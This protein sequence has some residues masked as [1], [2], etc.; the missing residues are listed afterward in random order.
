M[1]G[2][3]TQPPE[4]SQ[5][6]VGLLCR[7][8]P[9]GVH[10]QKV[11]H[12]DRGSANLKP[13]T[14]AVWDGQARKSQQRPRAFPLEQS[15]DTLIPLVKVAGMVVRITPT[16][17]AVLMVRFIMDLKFAGI[18]LQTLDKG[19]HT[20]RKL[21]GR[22]VVT[23]SHAVIVEAD[24]E[25]QI[26]VFVSNAFE[27]SRMGEA[28]HLQRFDVRLTDDLIVRFFEKLVIA[29]VQAYSTSSIGHLSALLNCIRRKITQFVT[30]YPIL[31][32]DY[33][34]RKPGCAVELIEY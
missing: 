26:G 33:T 34:G 18:G 23:S 7:S 13:F 20:L 15:E 11:G 30:I 4:A 32:Q 27:D 8:L 9:V 29:P 21:L 22:R 16:L 6:I 25:L 2:L 31:C 28:H 14:V 10:P 5:V 1:V 12:L 17:D 3:E 24:N 19:G